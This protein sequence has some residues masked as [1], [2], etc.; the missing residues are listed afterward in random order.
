MPSILASQGASS[1]QRTGP[2]MNVSAVGKEMFSMGEG[3]GHGSIQNLSQ[4]LNTLPVE[5]S[6]RVEA[7]RVP[8]SNCQTSV[9]TE[10]FGQE[11]LM[12]AFL[13]Q[14]LVHILLQIIWPVVFHN[15]S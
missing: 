6:M 4:H 11:D 12:N 8:D 15:H 14:F 10:H 9:F 5:N 3:N 2:V 7:E 1:G 13:M